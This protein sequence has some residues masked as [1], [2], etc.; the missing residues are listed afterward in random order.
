MT[1]FVSRFAVGSLHEVSH[2]ELILGQ[3]RRIHRLPNAYR[4]A[5]Q[6]FGSESDHHTVGQFDPMRVAK[7]IAQ[8]KPNYPGA[9]CGLS[10][11]YGSIAVCRGQPE[12]RGDSGSTQADCSWRGAIGPNGL[13]ADILLRPIAY[14]AGGPR[15]KG[16]DVQLAL[17][18]AFAAS[19]GCSML[20]CCSRATPTCSQRWSEHLVR[21]WRAR[22]QFGWAGAGACPRRTT[23]NG[24]TVSTIETMGNFKTRST[25]RVRESTVPVGV[26]SDRQ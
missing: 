17:D 12:T 10:L 14:G 22:R 23:S 1:G 24:S 15:E 8:R 11:K 9:K 26:A 4:G 7:A 3:A 6:A 2:E 19:D 5:R 16:I 25:T 20:W 13:R 18:L 21:A